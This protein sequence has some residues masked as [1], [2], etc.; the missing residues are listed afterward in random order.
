MAEYPRRFWQALQTGAEVAV[1]S[2]NPQK[3]LGVRDGFNSFFEHR[4][5]RPVSVVVVPQERAL[6]GP[7]LP[8]SD[9][10][11]AS[12]A[13]QQC[14]DLRQELGEHYL[15]FV[16]AEGGLDTLDVEDQTLCLARYWAAVSSELGESMGTSSGLQLPVRLIEGLDSSEIPFAVPGRRRRGGMLGS[17]TA[18]AETQR[19]AV[20]SATFNALSTLFYGIFASRSAPLH[21]LS[22][23]S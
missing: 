12:L 10:E 9:E 14:R 7:S 20:A 5:P 8:L 4:L 22:D 2:S 23:S 17:L 21:R 1:A 16:A 11:T 18:G 6:E 3:L 13:L 15:F 19:G